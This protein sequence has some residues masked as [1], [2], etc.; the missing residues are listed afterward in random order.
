ML[1]ISD[2][3]FPGNYCLPAGSEVLTGTQII[4][5]KHYE[6]PQRKTHHVNAAWCFICAMGKNV[7][8]IW[9]R[10]ISQFCASWWFKIHC[11]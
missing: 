11:V 9:V 6:P 2:P 8:K 3:S 5:P 7:V 1:L 4:C 10:I